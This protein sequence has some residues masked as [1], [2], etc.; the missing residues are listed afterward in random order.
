[1]SKPLNL[2]GMRFGRLTVIERT[3]NNQRGQSCWKCHC[4]CGNETV[5]VASDLKKGHTKS[6]GCSRSESKF[7]H[8]MAHTKISHIWRAIKDRCSNP[9]NKRYKHYGGRGITICDEWR[10]DFLA[11]YNYVSKLEHYGEEGY[12]LDRINNDGNYEPDNLRWADAKTQNHNTRKNVFIEYNGEKMT[13]A[14]ASK[15]SGINYATLLDRLH[16]GDTGDKLFRPVR[17]K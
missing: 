8:G 2:L 5:V 1:M 11:F 10:N 7:K 17:K 6:C 4:D 3:E 14:E 9:N 12:S 16:R 13:V 15:L